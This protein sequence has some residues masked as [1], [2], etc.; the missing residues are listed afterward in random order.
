MKHCFMCKW[1][2]GVTE[3]TGD[4]GSPLKPVLKCHPGGYAAKIQN[5]KKL[6][7]Y[8]DPENHTDEREVSDEQ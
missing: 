3:L 1:L 7:E 4:E 5:A 8:Y 6:C 2:L